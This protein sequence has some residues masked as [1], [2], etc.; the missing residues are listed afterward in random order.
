MRMKALL[1]YLKTQTEDN[2]SNWNVVNAVTPQGQ[3]VSGL[4]VSASNIDLVLNGVG[5]IN[6]DVN[7]SILSGYIS[8]VVN[9][10]PELSFMA[11]VR[12]DRF[13]YDGDKNDPSDDAKAYTKSTFSPKLGIVYQP[14][15]N[16][17]SVFGNYQK[18]ISY[19]RMEEKVKKLQ[20]S[21]SVM[22]S[23]KIPNKVKQVD[24]EKKN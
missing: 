8:D 9:I 3:L 15:L 20:D 23:N 13:N 18:D 7:Q 17:L 12:Y 4:P 24:S 16:K 10:L 1:D 6:T 11:G 14:I 5:N 22:S 2:S 21:L 19:L